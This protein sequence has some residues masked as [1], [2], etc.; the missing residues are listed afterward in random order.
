MRLDS[1]STRNR[2]L[3]SLCILASLVSLA[4]R[5]NADCPL[6]PPGTGIYWADTFNK[7]IG[8]ANLDGTFPTDA[9]IDTS[10]SAPSGVALNSIEIFWGHGDGIGEAALDGSRITKNWVTG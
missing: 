3:L 4:E 7:T 5:A 6:C 1:N 8:S 10:P 2:L 9:L